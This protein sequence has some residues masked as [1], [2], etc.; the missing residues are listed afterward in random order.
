M[1]NKGQGSSFEE[2]L[3]SDVLEIITVLS[4]RPYGSR[5]P[6]NQKLIDGVRQAVQEAPC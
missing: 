4:A 5:S 1:I 6:R 2:D 3:A